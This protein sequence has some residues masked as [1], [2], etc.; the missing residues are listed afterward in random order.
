MIFLISEGDSRG[1]DNRVAGV[2]ANG[3][4]VFHGADSDGVAFGI[5]NDFEFDFLPTADAFF[6]ENLVNRGGLQAVMR[7]LIEFFWGIANPTTAAA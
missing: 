4:E 5:A 6:N 3:V 1:D 2:H 7:N